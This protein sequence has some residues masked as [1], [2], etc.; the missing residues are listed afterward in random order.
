MSNHRQT[1]ELKLRIPQG[2]PLSTYTIEIYDYVGKNATE[3]KSIAILL[4]EKMGK[5]Y[6]HKLKELGVYNPGLTIGKGWVFSHKKED[7]L[8]ELLNEI[9]DGSVKP[10]YVEGERRTPGRRSPAMASPAKVRAAPISIPGRSPK[11]SAR[12]EDLSIPE[13]M[14]LLLEKMETDVRKLKVAGNIVMG[15]FEKVSD[16]VDMEKVRIYVATGDKMIAMTD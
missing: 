14:D 12:S 10:H 1:V 11:A 5:A 9:A 8:Y 13:L 7:A 6:A 4:P 3:S 2:A 15:P 16:M